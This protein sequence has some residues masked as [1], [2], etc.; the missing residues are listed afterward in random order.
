MFLRSFV[1]LL[2]HLTLPVL[3]SSLRSH[4]LLC[5][6]SLHCNHSN[7][8][9]SPGILGLPSSP[10]LFHFCSLCWKCFS[11][12]PLITHSL[13]FTSFEDFPDH[14]LLKAAPHTVVTPS[15]CSLLLFP[16]VCHIEFQ[17]LSYIFF[18]THMS[19]YA[20]KS[21]HLPKYLLPHTMQFSVIVVVVFI[22]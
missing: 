17:L 6:V 7:L 4:L 15:S 11:P 14:P 5:F 16:K 10:R 20:L 13:V 18:H 9:V 21:T 19:V 22:E 1:P 12:H 8:P 3:L 2:S